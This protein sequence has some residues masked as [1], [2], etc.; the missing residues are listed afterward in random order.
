MLL[1]ITYALQLWEHY[2]VR[3]WLPLVAKRKRIRLLRGMPNDNGVRSTGT[4][5]NFLGGFVS[6]HKAK[7]NCGITLRGGGENEAEQQSDQR[8]VNVPLTSIVVD[9]LWMIPCM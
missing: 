6:Q 9:A 1:S 8:K 3:S 7:H 4:S 5:L 2:I